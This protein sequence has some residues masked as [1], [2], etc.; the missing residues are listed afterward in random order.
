VKVVHIKAI[1]SDI[2]QLAFVRASQIIA[3]NFI[4]FIAAL[5]DQ[6]FLSMEWAMI[7]KGFRS[8]FSIWVFFS[9]SS[10]ALNTVVIGETGV[11][12]T[13]KNTTVKIVEPM[14]FVVLNEN[15]ANAGYWVGV[16]NP[17]FEILSQ[18]LP[19][20]WSI[21][22]AGSGDFANVAS[23]AISSAGWE[24]ANNDQAIAYWMPNTGTT[25]QPFLSDTTVY[26]AKMVSSN[27]IL[28][29]LKDGLY[30]GT[31]ASTEFVREAIRNT[32]V[33]EAIELGCQISPRPTQFSTS[34][35]FGASV[36]FVA[37]VEGNL[38]FSATWDIED[39]CDK[40]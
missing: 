37:G 18:G 1:K 7:R 5:Y 8:I 9:P 21:R 30:G 4:P 25:V 22:P 16:Q 35:T 6:Y 28:D 3:N 32:L 17:Q 26:S 31:V 15:G 14:N 38:N 20:Q 33:N 40:L 29:T 24:I 27:T 34:A 23:G 39:L 13:Q 2:K 10:M 12:Y 11:E 19:Q 36:S